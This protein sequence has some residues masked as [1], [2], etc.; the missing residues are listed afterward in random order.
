M[1]ILNSKK[2]WI[3]WYFWI[4]DP[5]NSILSSLHASERSQIFSDLWF[6]ILP[7]LA[8]NTQQSLA[9][10]TVGSL[11]FPVVPGIWPYRSWCSQIAALGVMQCSTNLINLHNLKTQSNTFNPSCLLLTN[12]EL[13]AQCVNESICSW[14][15]HYPLSGDG[16]V[17]VLLGRNVK[18]LCKALEDPLLLVIKQW[19]YYHWKKKTL[20]IQQDC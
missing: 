3:L 2:L 6:S 5:P 17:L 16:H 12:Q 13:L 1:K 20:G 11:S 10:G 18:V 7:L 19:M 8:C 15:H 14:M 9:K 4:L